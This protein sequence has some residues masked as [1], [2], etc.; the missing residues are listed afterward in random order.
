MIT[1]RIRKEMS[2]IT[3]DDRC[4]GFVAGLEG[5]DMLK[6]TCISAGYG[7]DHLIPA[8]W[9]SEVDRYVFLDKTASYV[10][11]NWEH[12]QTLI[13]GR[14]PRSGEAPQPKAA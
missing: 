13:R 6:I 1:D 4:I 12:A 5:E 11:A 2:V 3:A 7:Y 14:V 9:V 8:A 10:S